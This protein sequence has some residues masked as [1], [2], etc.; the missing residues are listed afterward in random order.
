MIFVKNPKFFARPWLA[1]GVIFLKCS[2]Y[3]AGGIGYGKQ[4]LT[5][6]HD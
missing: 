4:L 5:K 1:L 3:I 2:E 6:H